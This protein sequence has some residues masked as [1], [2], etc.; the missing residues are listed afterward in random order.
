MELN[1]S[2]LSKWVLCLYGLFYHFID[3]LWDCGKVRSGSAFVK[4]ISKMFNDDHRA[5]KIV[6]EGFQVVIGCGERVRMWQ[7]VCWD[8][9]PL[10]R[11]FPRI[12]ALALNKTGVVA[13]RI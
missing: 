10:M 4:N 5:V 7:D 11:A 2:K 9:V 3:L 8:S 1:S 12:Y 6:K 13:G